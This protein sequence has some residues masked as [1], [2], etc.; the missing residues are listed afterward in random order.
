MSIYKNTTIKLPAASAPLDILWDRWG[1]PHIYAQ[2]VE[3][4]YVG[5]GYVTGF[6]RLWQVELTRLYATGTAASVLGERFVARDAINRAFNVS[7][8][9][10][11][12]PDSEGDYLVDA[13]LSGLNGY[14]EQLAEVPPEF[15][16]AGTTPRHFTR[17]TVAA[18][19]RF[20]AWH[21]HHPW[22]Q[23]M[24]LGK[25]TAEHG[26]ERWRKH[27]QRFSDDDAALAE[28]CR[29]LYAELNM[30]AVK[31][32]LPTAHFGSNNWAI[33]AAHSASGKPMLATDPHQPHS[34]PNTF[35][36][37][38]LSAPGFDALGATL[39][40]SP[41]FMMGRTL[42]T[43][44]GL[45]TGFVDNSDVYIEE[46]DG[47]KYRTPDGW[48][49]FETIEETIEVKGD[50]PVKLELQRTRHGPL[51]EPLLEQL[52]MAPGRSDNYRTA[53]SWTLEHTPTTAGVLAR[54][55]LAESAAEFG[56][57]LA[58]DDHTP[59]VNNIICVDT[60][61]N[62]RRW[63]VSSIPKRKGATSMLPLP[64]WDAKYDWPLNTAA[65]ML[66]EENPELGYTATANNDTLEEREPFPI[67]TYHAPS[68]RADRIFELLGKKEKFT[69]RD[70]QDMQ[71]DLLDCGARDVLPGVLQ[72]LAETQDPM[73]IKGRDILAE[74][75]CQG[76][77]GSSG[78][79]MFYVFNELRWPIR[80]MRAALTAEGKEARLVNGFKYM[81][82]FNRFKVEDF[83]SEDSVWRE[84]E[85]LLKSTISDT[86]REAV[87][88]LSEHLGKD[89]E[90]WRWGDIHKISF[91]STLSKHNTWQD[92][93][94]GPDP[95]G[96]SANT[97]NMAMHTGRGPYN[98]Y[99]GPVFR[100]IADLADPMHTTLVMAGG[101]SARA[102]SHH[103]KD[104][105][106]LWLAGD[107]TT[108]HFERNA[109]ERNLEAR[110]RI[111][112]D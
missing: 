98:V 34:I 5:M 92:L 67:H 54:L 101:N 71:F 48:T 110:W 2:S 88:W 7:G 4:A 80:F 68:A 32:V 75:D 61:D 47:N 27:L 94:L 43:A 82:G 58:D 77:P 16:H 89:A 60:D 52:D 30:D 40:G 57:Y 18:H 38:H 23:K 91:G 26:V 81:A 84:H 35:F 85:I 72:A 108:V 111:T 104:Q 29:D 10:H 99:H 15:E 28:S 62:M 42:N 69:Q 93:T 19:Y 20:S 64:G 112:T 102:D 79:A 70:F 6:E 107:Y 109:V 21:Q 76:L 103:S 24:L 13:Y 65:D 25:L 39:P 44:W 46:V 63:V 3:D 17:D 90:Q 51:L 8:A 105:Y 37:V 49:E 83:L 1:I 73:A 100:M 33:N 66:V 96:G 97:L 14:I 22:P 86:V 9:R 87:S 59:L 45:T 74:W 55:P 78:A 95:V 36:F 50:E 11:E 12:R 41:Y 106:K 56:E 53:L 31:L